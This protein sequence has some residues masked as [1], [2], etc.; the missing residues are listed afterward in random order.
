MFNHCKLILIIPPTD[1]A[2]ASECVA[3][4]SGDDELPIINLTLDDENGIEN[5]APTPAE[6]Q[7]NPSLMAASLVDPATEAK[8][9]PEGMAIIY[10]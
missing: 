8:D 9:R 10:K 4:E 7:R 3:G 1:G 2:V 6:L 5:E